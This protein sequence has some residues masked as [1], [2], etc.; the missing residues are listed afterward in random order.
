LDVRINTIPQPLE[1]NNQTPFQDLPPAM[2]GLLFQPWG[3]IQE[4]VEIMK[5]GAIVLRVLFIITVGYSVV[6]IIAPWITLEGD[7]QVVT[8]RRFEGVLE[9]GPLFVAMLCGRSGTARTGAR[10]VSFRQISNPCMKFGLLP[11]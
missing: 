5:A 4:C 10:M 1:W 7:F 6:G 2:M 9:A 3:I 11:N 8:G